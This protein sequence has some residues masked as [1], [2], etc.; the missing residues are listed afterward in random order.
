MVGEESLEFRLRK[1]DEQEIIFRW[2]KKKHYDLMSEKYKKTCQF[3]NY[4]ENLFLLVPVVTGCFS[5]SAFA[6]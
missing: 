4:V 2:K 3:L 1:T 6:S 5:I